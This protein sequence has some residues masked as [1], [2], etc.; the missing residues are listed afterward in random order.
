M[1]FHDGSH[2][3]LTRLAEKGG[4]DWVIRAQFGHASPAMMA[5]YSH[6]RRKAVEEAAT[7]L[8][9]SAPGG[10]PTPHASTTIAG[11]RGRR[12]TSH[13]TSQRAARRGKLLDLSRKSGS[14]GW[15]QTINPPVTSLMRVQHVVDSS[16]V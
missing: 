11:P 10:A 12:V 1:R 14:S 5:I 4:P 3:A 6:V 15:T 2:T 13:V 9:P 8:E 7:A 16:W